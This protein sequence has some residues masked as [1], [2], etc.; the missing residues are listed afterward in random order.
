MQFMPRTYDGWRAD[1]SVFHAANHLLTDGRWS[2]K[3]DK[4][5]G[6]IFGVGNAADGLLMEFAFGG[7]R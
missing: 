3:P 6:I 4:L 2:R 7:A 1:A 5:F